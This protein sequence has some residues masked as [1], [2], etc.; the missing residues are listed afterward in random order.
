MGNIFGFLGGQLLNKLL[1]F[2]PKMLQIIPP[3]GPITLW[4]TYASVTVPSPNL[5]CSS[6]HKYYFQV[7]LKLHYINVTFQNCLNR[8]GEA[9]EGGWSGGKGCPPSPWFFSSDLWQL[10]NWDLLVSGRLTG[11]GNNSHFPL[12]NLLIPLDINRNVFLLPGSHPA[13]PDYF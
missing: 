3:T 13:S 4:G 2:K 9:E 7:L 12:Q 10:K 1:L 5:G 6:K 8:G 11:W